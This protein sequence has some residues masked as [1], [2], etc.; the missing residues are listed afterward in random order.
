MNTSQPS[1]L[2]QQ[3]IV[4]ACLCSSSST[5]K[6]YFRET[7]S[8]RRL[9]VVVLVAGR[10]TSWCLPACLLWTRPEIAGCPVAVS[11]T[12]P[13]AA[14]FPVAGEGGSRW[15]TPW[16]PAPNKTAF[17]TL[18]SHLLQ[19]R[20]RRRSLFA[21]GST[22]QTTV[23]MYMYAES[24][25]LQEMAV[26]ECCEF[27]NSCVVWLN[28]SLF[29]YLHVSHGFFMLGKFGFFCQ[30]FLLNEACFF[31]ASLLVLAVLLPWEGG[32]LVLSLCLGEL[33]CCSFVCLAE[34]LPTTRYQSQSLNSQFAPSPS[35]SPSASLPLSF[36]TSLDNRTSPTQSV[37]HSLLTQ[38]LVFL[39]LQATRN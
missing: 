36:T 38:A 11:T 5:Q 17:T 26:T 35:P 12:S 37:S 30:T 16:D 1:H 9:M 10:R 8:Y 31:F 20:E 3:T 22:D 34:I 32:R 15:N 4:D 13:V 25:S 7:L 21:S 27:C 33:Q 29:V 6:D 2:S 24:M 39:V 28:N 23:C 19:V 14:L 18:S